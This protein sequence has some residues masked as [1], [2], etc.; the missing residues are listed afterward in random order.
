[1]EFKQIF[2]VDLNERNCPKLPYNYESMDDIEKEEYLK[3]ERSL[4]YIAV[5]RA[6]ENVEI[7]EVGEKTKLICSVLT[8]PLSMVLINLHL[9]FYNKMLSQLNIHY[10][11][12]K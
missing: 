7:T 4:L 10:I 8:V 12:V 3:N 1:M 11:C 5:S 9:F 6:I 2:I